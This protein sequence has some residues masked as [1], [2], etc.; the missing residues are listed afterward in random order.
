MFARLIFVNFTIFCHYISPQTLLICTIH[1][2]ICPQEI[3][4]IIACA[5]GLLLSLFLLFEQV[6]TKNEKF[7]YSR[8]VY[9]KSQKKTF[10]QICLCRNRYAFFVSSLFNHYRDHSCLCY[11]KRNISFFL[12]FG[13]LRSGD[14]Y[15]S[16][17][18]E[19]IQYDSGTFLILIAAFTPD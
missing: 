12:N 3:L 10:G 8:N 14:T 9:V 19:N 5:L 17:K 7:H 1:E 15:K 6:H 2:K 16:Q 18:T 11:S 4:M 13:C